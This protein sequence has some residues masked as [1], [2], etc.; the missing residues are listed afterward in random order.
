M[1]FVTGH[2]TE[3]GTANL[4]IEA[5]AS[6]NFSTSVVNWG[7]GVINSS[8]GA[9]LD[10]KSG[11]VFNGNWTANS[12]GLVVEN[13]GNVDVTLNFRA[14]KNAN[15]FIGGTNPSYKWLF[16]NK[17]GGSCINA[18]DSSGGW[19]NFSEVNLTSPGTKVCDIFYFRNDYDE[20]RIH[21]NL[22]LPID[23]LPGVK[24]D[25]ITATAIAI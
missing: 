18:T 20:I 21:F 8:S 25:T 10:T 6:I 9:I 7:S 24:G 11:T 19:G 22:T 5:Y 23:T 13:I 12:E 17:E 2:A 4:T 14:G 15:E 16:E 3:T 1:G